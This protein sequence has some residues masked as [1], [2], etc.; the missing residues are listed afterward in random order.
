VKVVH[1]DVTDASIIQLIVPAAVDHQVMLD[2]AGGVAVARNRRLPLDLIRQV[3][4]LEADSCKV[5]FD[6]IFLCFLLD[7]LVVPCILN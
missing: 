3:A 4:N 7:F 2:E 1:S 6:L 5:R